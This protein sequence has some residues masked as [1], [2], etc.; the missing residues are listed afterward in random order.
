MK[1]SNAYIM[2]FVALALA[3]SAC[4]SSRLQVSLE[5]E[6]ARIALTD[7]SKVEAEL[8]AVTDSVL[9]V[10]ITKGEAL[11]GLNENERMVGI[12]WDHI[13]VIEVQGFANRDWLFPWFTMQVLPPILFGIAATRYGIGGSEVIQIIF[14]TGIPAILSG[15]S[16]GGGGTRNPVFKNLDDVGLRDALKPYSRYPTGLNPDQVNRIAEHIGQKGWRVIRT[17]S[18]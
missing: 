14:V 12:P 17:A 16:I 3:T 6:N 18:D 10:N 11:L 15:A 7:D 13:I 2:A 8:I 1:N 5:G 4:G 9:L